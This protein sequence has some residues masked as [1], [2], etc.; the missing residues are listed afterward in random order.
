MQEY[1]IRILRDDGAPTIIMAGTHRSD[2]SAI[3]AART[4]ARGK[5]FEVW[6]GMECITGFAK[7]SRSSAELSLAPSFRR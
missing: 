6:R 1:E 5:Q 7:T 2:A 4:I 3:W